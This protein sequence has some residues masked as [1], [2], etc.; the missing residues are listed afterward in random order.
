MNLHPDF[1][2]FI[3]LLNNHGVEYLVVGGYAVVVHGYVRATGDIDIWIRPSL[4]NAMK[5]VQVLN[6]FGFGSLGLTEAEF[7]KDDTI[8]QFGH[9]PLRI[10]LLTTPERL[11][12]S[13]CYAKRLQ[14]EIEKGLIL[15]VVDLESLKTNKLAV[16]RAKDLDDLENLK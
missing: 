13:E 2:E 8:V 14:V 7:Q 6:E 15:N 11:S 12:F 9:P 16:G 1:K 5:V 10:D 4:N 3:R